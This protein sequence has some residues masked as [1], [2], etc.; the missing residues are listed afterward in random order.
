MKVI[1]ANVILNEMESNLMLMIL[2]SYIIHGNLFCKLNVSFVLTPK[3][4]NV[5]PS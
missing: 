2:I 1:F 3:I 4:L 5:M